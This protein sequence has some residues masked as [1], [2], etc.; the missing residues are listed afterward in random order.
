MTTRW[1]ELIGKTLLI[2]ALSFFTFFLVAARD[3][4]LTFFQWVADALLATPAAVGRVLQYYA[5]TSPAYTLPSLL[6]G[7][8]IGGV[9]ITTQ[10]NRT[11]AYIGL[12]VLLGLLGSQV[13]MLPLRHC[14]FLPETPGSQFI[15]GLLIVAAGALVIVFPL[16]SL[17]RQGAARVPQQSGRYRG[18]LI[19]VLFLLP[20]VFNLLIFIYFPSVRTFTLSLN[21]RRFPL[22][23]ERFVCLENYVNLTQD[24]IY[25]NSFI[26]TMLMTAAIVLLS[27]S[28]GLGI[29]LLASQKIKYG[30][31]YR[32]LLLIPVALSPVVSGIIILM[33]FREGRAGLLNAL[34]FEMG[35]EPV[36]W[37]RD[38]NWARV[39]V[40]TAAVW[41]ILGFNIL[42]Y[43]A[44]I[45]NVRA[46]LL[47]AAQ[48]DGANRVQRFVFIMFPLLAPFTFFL[49]VTN[50]TYAFYGIYGVVDTLTQGG[51]PIGAAGSLGGATDVL[52]YKLYQDAFNPGSPAG[53]AAAQAVILFVV[54]LGVTLLQFR[55]ID[56]SITYGE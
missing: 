44:G 22:P 54:A 36:R 56:T 30:A 14:T 39:T 53:L 16:V 52:I 27:L 31:V 1:P 19:P 43:I 42:F 51:P 48:I 5:E 24:A 23:Q 46:D 20:I 10:R 11:T 35:A 18:Y 2:I 4:L 41:N 3:G 9:W 25:Q 17:V 6:M 45:Q 34:L 29:A 8:V 26:T 28:L 32:T 13:F 49:L 21:L 15:P 33:L 12:G 55:T 40:I 7:A 38:P 50:V 47:E 37:L